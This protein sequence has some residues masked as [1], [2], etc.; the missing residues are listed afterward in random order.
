MCGI[1]GFWNLDGKPIS[2]EEL[3]RFTHQI[4]HRGPDGWDVHIFNTAPVGF[5]HRRLA[6][7]DTT[8]AGRQPMS[9]INR[10]WMVFN[11]EL[12]NFVELR[13]ELES[14][15]YQ[16]KTDSDTEVVLASYDKWGEDC[17]FKFNGMWALVIWDNHERKLFASR[18]RFGVKPLIYSFDSK[19]FAFAS[20]MKA[21]LALD[22]F[23]AEFS[24]TVL[25]NSL[26]DASLVE[27]TEDCLLLG[28]FSAGSRA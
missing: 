23:R 14:S 18:D 10:Y 15:G 16:F 6:I 17:Q 13:K 11:G 3:I 2:R 4:V 27:G 9:F 19:R 28:A 5:G 8:D 7:I 1:T 22:G 26:N 24:P 20:E 12:Y 25:T 21:F